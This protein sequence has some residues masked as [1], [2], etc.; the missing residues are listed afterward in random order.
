MNPQNPRVG[1]V[2]GGR[3]L[4]G[5]AIVTGLLE[6]RVVDQVWSLD[7]SA[8]VGD[9]LTAVTEVVCDLRDDDQLRAA[10]EELPA[11]VDCYVS[12]LGG[13]ENPPVEPVHDTAWP[14]PAV[15]DD[16]VALN[17]GSAY[18]IVRSLEG[19]LREGASITH[20]SSIAATMPWVVSPA[21]GAAKSAL[22]HWTTSLAVL[23]GP[24]GI[25]VNAVR[26]GF[27]WSRQWA[28]V[29]RGEFDAV[30]ADRVPLAQFD[31]GETVSREQLPT[32]VAEAVVFLASPAARQ[33]TGQF[34]DVDGGA[35]LVR[36][37]R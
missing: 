2:V 5:R 4:I 34:L 23:L 31:Q 37:A 7:R 30:V 24:R 9:H 14:P 15:W 17:T 22:E 27:V 25:R 32:D 20:I 33:L 18:R 3:G 26:P 13:E 16:I 8:P 12:V 28:A 1:I 35:A 36:A 19:R 21:Y 10:V 6:R 11:R 29:D